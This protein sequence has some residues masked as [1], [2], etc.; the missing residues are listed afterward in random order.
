MGEQTDMVE[1]K[2]RFEE[3]KNLMEQGQDL[4]LVRIIADHGSAPRGAGAG[5][6]V[7]EDGS[8]L[9]TIGG[10]AVEYQ[11]GLLAQEVL[12]EKRSYIRGFSLSREQV[13]DLGMICGGNVTVY[14]QYID[15]DNQTFLT[16]CRAVLDACEQNENSWL[17]TDLTDE[18]AWRMGLYNSM[19]KRIGMETSRP[20][21]SGSDTA[22]FT[23]KAVTVSLNGHTYYS[24][25]L[26]KAGRVY[27]FGGGHVSQELVPV[28]SHLGFSCVV[29]DDR[30][31]FAN[32]QVFPQAER[33]VL[34]DFEDISRH[35]AVTEY[36]Y[37][38]I[39]T[40]GHQYDYLLQ[41]QAL[42]TP[43]RYIGVMGSR[44]KIKAINEKLRQEGFGERDLERFHTPI[45]LSILAETPAEIAVSIAAELISVRA[46]KPSLQV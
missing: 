16:L 35:I 34:D 29:Y 43:A 7:R 2:Q 42:A 17:V 24:E 31:E 46:A 25:P 19:G 39:M 27:V 20:E 23:N 5:M 11:A 40:R 45:G 37:M 18:A 22:L 10:G 32:P 9:G 28:L 12:K 44:N 15:A 1:M 14:F 6:L 3:I 8:T 13:S 38:V 41:R 33:I 4:V 26:V 21:F 36:D 30:V